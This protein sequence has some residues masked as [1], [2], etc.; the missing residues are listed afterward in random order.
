MPINTSVIHFVAR[1]DKL[2]GGIN[3]IFLKPY[4]VQAI[5]LTYTLHWRASV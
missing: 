4:L 3:A 1:V 5:P 2:R